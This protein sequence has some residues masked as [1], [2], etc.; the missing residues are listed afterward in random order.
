MNFNCLPKRGKDCRLG[1]VSAVRKIAT[2]SWIFFVI[3]FVCYFAV[4]LLLKPG[5]F[6]Y[7][8]NAQQILQAI[9]LMDLNT[10]HP[11]LHTLFMGV[12]N[13]DFNLDLF[14]LFQV[15]IYALC[16][17]FSAIIL[18][19]HCGIKRKALIIA[20]LIYSLLPMFQIGSVTWQKDMFFAAFFLLFVS[21]VA[22]LVK[23][24]AK[25]L[26]NYKFLITLTT[27][28]FL[29]CELRKNAIVVPF[30]VFII[31]LLVY[32]QRNIRKA[33]LVLLVLIGG[34]VGCFS[35]IES[36]VATI[37]NGGIGEA[38]S[39]PIQQVGSIMSD[40]TKLIPNDIR[41]RMLDI[42]GQEIWNDYRPDFS[43][44]IKGYDG[45]FEKGSHRQPAYFY[46]D[47]L[48][49]GVSYS[50]EYIQAFW[51]LEGEYIIPKYKT[52]NPEWQGELHENNSRLTLLTYGHLLC[53]D[54]SA[55]NSLEQNIDACYE[56]A[57]YVIQEQRPDMSKEDFRKL[58]TQVGIVHKN[59]LSK[60]LADMYI[61]FYNQ[62]VLYNF[63]FNNSSLAFWG[64]IV[65]IVIYIVFRRLKRTNLDKSS[66]IIVML[67]PVSLWLVTFLSS[68]IV[69]LRYMYPVILCLPFL[70]IL[71]ISLKTKP[72]K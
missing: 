42:N 39:I 13:L 57:Q 52:P 24:K 19:K 62:P 40:D 26:L 3:P 65:L 22:C 72:D 31:C 32:K 18:E 50:I 2:S 69:E 7:T 11:I 5:I 68:P 36:K 45:F 17:G 14:S 66:F 55:K 58:A 51:D 60:P 41:Q 29:V 16:I 1:I 21:L 28:S 47:W 64:I 27:I 15:I 9:N 48:K 33:L 49:L 53:K 30:I 10:W 67:A 59:S 44:P 56:Q 38:S 37:K 71:L 20:V 12:I 70:F 54:S 35:L 63:I 61:G 25:L 46:I 43:D 4:W 34:L 23:T 8:D 6:S